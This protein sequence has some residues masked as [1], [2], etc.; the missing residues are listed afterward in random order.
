M[1]A[2]GHFP[3]TR[4]SLIARLK[5]ADE[6]AAK[7]AIEELCRQYHYPLYCYLRRRGL[8]HHDAED[9]LHDFLAKLLRLGSFGDA[10]AQKGRLRAFL[11][12][13]LQRFL[14]NWHESRA[15]RERV[16]ALD[17]A[18]AQERYEREIFRDGETP[19]HL[20]DRKWAQALLTRVLVRLG[21][22][23]AARGKA[24]VFATLRP[25]VTEGGSLRGHDATALA[26]ALGSNEVALRKTLSRLMSDYRE[27]LRAEVEQTADDADAELA[28]LRQV[29][30]E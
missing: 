30:A 6:R 3:A 10:D 25:V 7:E 9:V 17:T 18:A 14:L 1:P 29:F 19:E 13:S 20:F 16:V 2:D 26:A 21:E 5:S 24:D 11:C 22:D 23:Y 27:V 4:W 15:A 8:A 12:T 28:H